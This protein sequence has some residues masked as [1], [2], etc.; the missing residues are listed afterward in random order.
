MKDF[1]NS[2]LNA[3]QPPKS[4]EIYLDS[5]N[6]GPDNDDLVQTQTV[7]DHILNFPNFVKGKNVFY[8]L[9]DGKY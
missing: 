7:R 9:D 2:I 4:V 5:G 6:E 8:Y 1:N 3:G